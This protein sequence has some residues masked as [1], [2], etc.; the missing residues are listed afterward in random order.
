M[1]VKYIHE[2]FW[3]DTEHWEQNFHWTLSL[4]I[5]NI[6]CALLMT[7]ISFFIHITNQILKKKNKVVHRN[8]I[9]LGIMLTGMKDSQNSFP[10]LNFYLICKTSFPVKRKLRQDKKRP[11]INLDPSSANLIVLHS[12]GTINRKLPF[13]VTPFKSVCSLTDTRQKLQ[14]WERFLALQLR[15]EY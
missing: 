10:Q 9:C 1:K 6:S 3:F 13:S 8:V 5:N 15:R 4:Y 2:K 14:A 11:R 7:W 12:H